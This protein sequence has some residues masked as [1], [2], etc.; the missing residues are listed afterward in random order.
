MISCS[1]VTGPRVNGDPGGPIT[2]IWAHTRPSLFTPGS[3]SRAAGA[4]GSAGGEQASSRGAASAIRPC[5][6]GEGLAGL[7]P[8]GGGRP[9]EGPRGPRH[10][11]ELGQVAGQRVPHQMARPSQADQ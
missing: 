11:D 3:P 8:M 4:N 10:R 6:P 1:R 7:D 2:A 9:A 5:T